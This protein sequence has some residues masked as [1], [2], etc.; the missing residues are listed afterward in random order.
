[1]YIDKKEK[2]RSAPDHILIQILVSRRYM[3]RLLLAFIEPFNMELL[4]AMHQIDLMLQAKATV[5]TVDRSK[6]TLRM[7]R[8][9]RDNA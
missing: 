8:M 3:T 4:I 6:S 2:K 7:R 1:M 5:P 9:L